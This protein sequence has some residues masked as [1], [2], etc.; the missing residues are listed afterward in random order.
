MTLRF[1][2]NGLGR[3]GRGLARLSQARPELGLV[4]AAA[5]DPAEPAQIARL[6]RHDISSTEIRAALKAEV[7]E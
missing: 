6:F 7:E 1:G 5:N 3:I 4:F 2:I